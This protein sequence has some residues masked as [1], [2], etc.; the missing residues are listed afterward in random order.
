MAK[1]TKQITSNHGIYIQTFYQN[2]GKYEGEYTEHWAEGDK[3]IKTKGQYENGKKTGLW[4]Y[5]NKYGNKEKEETFANDKLEGKQ[6]YYD[7]KDVSK[8]YY[9]KNDVKDGEY[10]IYRSNNVLLEKG[11]YVNNR[12]EGLRTYYYPNGK[13]K[14]EDII[15]HNPKGERIER[16]YSQTGAILLERRYENG[17]QV[18]EKQYSED[19]KLKRVL[20]RNEAGKLAEV[21]TNN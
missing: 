13:P 9:Y 17:L 19:G 21:E 8:Y 2:N 12:V 11:T 18:G 4:E 5:G 10:A 3:A 1:Q 15:P 14:T 6:T 16:E 20:Q 7:G